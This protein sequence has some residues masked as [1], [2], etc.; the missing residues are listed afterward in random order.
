MGIDAEMFVIVPRRLHPSE[1][2][3]ESVRIAKAFPGKFFIQ[4]PEEWKNDKG[5]V[6]KRA[7]QH[8]LTLTREYRQDG[9]TIKALENES[10]VG[11]LAEELTPELEQRLW[12]HFCSDR[13]RAYYEDHPSPA[14]KCDFCKIP[15]NNNMWGGGKTGLYCPSCGAHAIIQNGATT[16]LGDTYNSHGVTDPEAQLDVLQTMLALVCAKQAK[17]DGIQATPNDLK[18]DRVEIKSNAEVTWDVRVTGR[19]ESAYEAY[20]NAAQ[21]LMERAKR[22]R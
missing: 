21:S 19:L 18:I 2:R 16:W 3:R 12:D 22:S 14:L 4:R 7:G 13:G 10:F 1:V 11:V 5:E 17:V 15:M 8:A 9:P 20:E 6:A